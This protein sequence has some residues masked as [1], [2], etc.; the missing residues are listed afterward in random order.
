MITLGFYK[1]PGI[2]VDRVIRW[3]TRSPY[4]HVEVLLDGIPEGGSTRTSYSA[5]GRDGGVREKGITFDAGKWDFVSVPW[6]DP[7]KAL[8]IFSQEQGSAYDWLGLILS[9]VLNLHRGSKGRWFCSELIAHVLGLPSPSSW[10]RGEVKDIVDYLNRI[11]P[12][13]IV[14]E[15]QQPRVAS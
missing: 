2:W 1:G 11:R 13:D 15:A 12:F 8:A 9:Q 5:S 4:S 14:S 6:V 3:A 10:S 7:I